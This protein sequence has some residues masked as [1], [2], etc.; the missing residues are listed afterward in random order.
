MSERNIFLL[1][2][3]LSPN[4]SA[5]LPKRQ[6]IAGQRTVRLLIVLN[7]AQNPINNP[8]VQIADPGK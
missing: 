5:N 1:Y 7:D 8:T 4:K 3:H 6:A 2:N